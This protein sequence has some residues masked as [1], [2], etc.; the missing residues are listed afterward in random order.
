MS[1]KKIQFFKIKFGNENCVP[2]KSLLPS[3][4]KGKTELFPLWKRGIK[5]DLK[6]YNFV[7]LLCILLISFL[8][9]IPHIVEA[10]GVGTSGNAMLKIGVGARATSMG[11]ASVAATDDVTSIY[12]NP[13]GLV[14][15][16]NSQISAMHIEWFDDI[17]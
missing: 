2:L 16:R 13:A 8:L 7:R 17:R 14:L 10:G 4:L 9:L 11:E 15:V 12:W 6:A 1:R 3:L 5:G